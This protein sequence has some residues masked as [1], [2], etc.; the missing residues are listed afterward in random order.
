MNVLVHFLFLLLTILR[1]TSICVSLLQLFAVKRF[2]SW[3][4]RIWVRRLLV[5]WRNRVNLWSAV[6]KR[7]VRIVAGRII[8]VPIVTVL[9]TIIICRKSFEVKHIIVY[10]IIITTF[11]FVLDR[12]FI[13]LPMSLFIVKEGLLATSLVTFYRIHFFL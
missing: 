9:L 11:Q 2:V 12:Y 6:R 1:I 8:D 13:S 10:W 3:Q 5:A 7:L 4:I